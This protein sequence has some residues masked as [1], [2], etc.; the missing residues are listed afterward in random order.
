M[1]ENGFTVTG[2]TPTVTATSV[3]TPL[4]SGNSGNSNP[5]NS[6]RLSSYG[7][8]SSGAQAGQTMTFAVNQPVTANAPGAII[9]VGV[10]P[11][12]NLG[13][14]VITVADATTIDTSLIAGRQTAHIASI[15]LVGV[16]PSAISQGTITFAVTGNWLSQHDVAP[17]DIVLMRNHDGQWS[18]LATTFDHQSG[19]T[20]YFVATTPGFSY[21]GI[22][23][24]VNAETINASIVT[25]TPVATGIPDTVP[26][27]APTTLP[28]SLS[29][30][31]PAMIQ[32]TAIPASGAGPAGS[33]GSPVITVIAGIG[34]IVIVAAGGFF[35]RRW[36]IRRQNP[37]L[38]RKYE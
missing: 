26:P 7:V 14:T 2:V 18:E 8:T 27:P 37:V 17:Y 15:E 19:D 35:V 21:F 4:S 5:V 1:L 23:T 30:P 3:I 34:G 32:T 12:T 29:A 16:N 6:G 11:A 20:Y 22:T 24:R 31:R 36:W 13:P 28:T 9:S 25:A 33:S 38:F 10:I